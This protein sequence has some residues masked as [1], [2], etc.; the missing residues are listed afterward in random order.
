MCRYAIQSDSIYNVEF[1]TRNVASPDWRRQKVS[2]DLLPQRYSNS[3]SKTAGHPSGIYQ[4][5]RM[6]IKL[7]HNVW[8]DTRTTDHTELLVMLALADFS[9]DEGR[10]YP[11]M[12]TIARKARIEDRS[13]R[14]IIGRLIQTGRLKKVRQGG[15]FNRKTI[16][17]EY[18]I[19]LPG[20]PD[21]SSPGDR[22][23]VCNPS[24]PR[25]WK[26]ISPLVHPLIVSHLL[27]LATLIQWSS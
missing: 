27:T 10:C 14:R 16:P 9:N 26:I 15:T 11:S 8:E 4:E 19:R 6:S 2:L 3:K 21:Y 22:K 1:A 18:Q 23:S 7:I 24:N 17:N 12:R 20:P 5:N 13:V 25:S